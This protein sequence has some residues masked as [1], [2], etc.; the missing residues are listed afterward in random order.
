MDNI[1]ST[2]S[3]PTPPE[4]KPR[5]SCLPGWRYFKQKGD[6]TIELGYLFEGPAVTGIDKAIAV[7]LTNAENVSGK[8]SKPHPNSRQM[9]CTAVNY[10]VYNKYVETERNGR[11]AKPL[12]PMQL[13]VS[14]T[15]AFLHIGC[16]NHEIAN[17]ICRNKK[18]GK[19]EATVRGATFCYAD[20]MPGM[21]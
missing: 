12:L 2:V 20:D 15:E 1:T 10:D 4:S 17:A 5:T 9:I 13:F 3:S 7:A 11:V 16:L 14:E 21:D 19:T 6:Q 18:Q 8:G